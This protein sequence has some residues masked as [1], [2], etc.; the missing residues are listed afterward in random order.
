[1]INQVLSVLHEVPTFAI[2]A[3]KFGSG[4]RDLF[5]TNFF[6]QVGHS[7]F[8]RKNIDLQVQRGAS[9]CFLRLQKVYGLII[10][11]P[12]SKSCDYT[13]VAKSVQTLNL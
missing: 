9:Q 13:I 1:M 4:L 2:K 3:S 6:R 11:L 5:D 7:L 8:L 12:T 10:Y